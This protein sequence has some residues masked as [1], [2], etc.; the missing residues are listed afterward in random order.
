MNSFSIAMA[1]IVASV[2]AHA[3]IGETRDQAERRYGLPK[4]EKPPAYAT[5]LLK[6]AR[7]LEYHYQ[8]YRIRCALLMATDGNEYIVRQDYRRLKG[9]PSLKDFEVSAILEGERNGAQWTAKKNTDRSLGI[10]QAE[11]ILKQALTGVE[12]VRPDGAIAR[13]EFGRTGVRLELP[14]AAQHEARLKAIKEQQERAAVPK[15]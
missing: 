6:G 5:P 1:V 12:M 15:F 9:A 14:Q 2:S 10:S 11:R 7:E 4:S 8:G 13:V 3:R